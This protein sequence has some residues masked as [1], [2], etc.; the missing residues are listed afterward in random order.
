MYR[1]PK[2]W[3]K[4][5]T[6]SA[7]PAL[8][9]ALLGIVVTIILTSPFEQQSVDFV[10]GVVLLFVFILYPLA[11]FL[12]WGLSIMFHTKLVNKLAFDEDVIKYQKWIAGVSSFVFGIVAYAIALIISL[13]VR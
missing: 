11:F 3:T 9:G 1:N 5:R 7:V 6:A 8:V 2:L 12:G 4:A 13:S 10:F